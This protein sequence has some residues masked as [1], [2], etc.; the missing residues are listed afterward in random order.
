[1]DPD[2]D[3]GQTW[4]TWIH[5]FGDLDKTALRLKEQYPGWNVWFVPHH[6]GRAA[7]C[8]QPWPRI[9]AWSPGELEDEIRRAHD[10]ADA[11]WPALRHISDGRDHTSG[12]IPD[13]GI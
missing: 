2:T 5:D 3:T 8:A 7:W 13:V 1:M 9:E 11:D 12:P 6:D 4:K 10:E